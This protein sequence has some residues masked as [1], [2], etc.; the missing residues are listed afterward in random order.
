MISVYEDVAVDDWP[1]Y[2]MRATP[3]RGGRLDV[4]LYDAEAEYRLV[5]D[6]HGA[7][8]GL[9]AAA[10]GGPIVVHGAGVCPIVRYTNRFDLEGRSTGEIEPFIP[11][12]GKI[13]QTSFDRLVV[14]RFASWSLSPRSD[15]EKNPDEMFAHK[16]AVED[17]AGAA[18]DPIGSYRGQAASAQWLVR[19]TVNLLDWDT[20]VSILLAALLLL[21]VL[22]RFCRDPDI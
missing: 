11:V 18:T 19:E 4:R 7:T 15:T 3:K 16:A 9:N 8:P 10:E 13:D 5:V 6:Q 14:Q 2:A 17:E 22:W 21:T 20:W 12:L 1:L